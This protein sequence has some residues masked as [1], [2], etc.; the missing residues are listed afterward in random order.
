MVMGVSGAGKTTLAEALAQRLNWTFVECDALHPSA[1]IE[2]MRSGIPLTDADRE[3]WLDAIAERLRMLSRSGV[4][5]GHYMPAALLDSQLAALEEPSLDER[6][7]TLDA[8]SK[9]M[10]RRHWPRSATA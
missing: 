4:R 2:K 8:H 5:R 9:P 6:P 1:N 3:P 10:S 7:L